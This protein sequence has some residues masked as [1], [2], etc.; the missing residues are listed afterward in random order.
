M[1]RR[2]PSA[3]ASNPGRHHRPLLTAGP[4]SGPS[5]AMALH[6]LAG[7][8]FETRHSMGAPSEFGLHAPAD[9]STFIEQ[10]FLPT[11]TQARPEPAVTHP[12]SQHDMTEQASA[13]LNQDI[14]VVRSYSEPAISQSHPNGMDEPPRT[15]VSS[16]VN[17]DTTTTQS[18]SEFTFAQT[19]SQLAITQNHSELALPEANLDLA[20]DLKPAESIERQVGSKPT[21][22]QTTPKSATSQDLAQASSPATPRPAAFQ[23]YRKLTPTR[24]Y[25]YTAQLAADRAEQAADLAETEAFHRRAV[26]LLV[27]D[28]ESEILEDDSQSE[29]YSVEP[30]ESVTP[31]PLEFSNTLG[32][33]DKF[34]QRNDEPGELSP[35]SAHDAVMP[36]LNDFQGPFDF[37]PTVQPSQPFINAG[38]PNNGM[39]LAA[40]YPAPTHMPT[41]MPQ[42]HHQ[43]QPYAPQGLQMQVAMGPQAMRLG[44]PP[45]M[46]QQHV[47]H[48]NAPHPYQ[49]PQTYQAPQSYQASRQYVSPYPPVHGQPGSPQDFP[50]TQFGHQM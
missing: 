42:A 33:E 15:Q 25:S 1:H 12:Y 20:N 24:S 8:P 18:N 41:M 43:L 32:E 14:V 11:N 19:N 21:A 2:G 34:A 36:A 45:N 37:M 10:A 27:M 40:M 50:H 16:G 13:G 17:Q 46:F 44:Y 6:S 4:W 26:S 35:I 22:L 23:P 9:D 38:Y 7:P 49:A 5:N 30:T 28:T 31:T 29:E 3:S 47:P 48:Y 39:H